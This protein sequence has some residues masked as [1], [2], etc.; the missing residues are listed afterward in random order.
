MKSFPPGLTAYHTLEPANHGR[1]AFR[2]VSGV[3]II[4]ADYPVDLEKLAAIAEDLMLFIETHY[5]QRAMRP[6]VPACLETIRK[7]GLKIGL[8]SNVNSRGQV[9]ANLEAYGIRHYF[10]PIV[11]SSEYGRR[12]P[13][14]AI[15]HYAARL[16]NVPT[17]ACALCRRP[18]RPRYPWRPAG[19]ISLARSRSSMIID[20]GED[21][22][23][24]HP[25]AVIADMTELVDILK[26]DDGRNSVPNS[27]C[28]RQRSSIRALL[29]D[30]GDILYFRPERGRK[31]RAFLERVRSSQTKVMSRGEREALK[32]QAYHGADL[33]GRI[34]ARRFLRLY[35][36]DRSG[37][38]RARQTSHGRG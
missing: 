7:M 8:I 12:K 14:P 21:G 6:E 9:P 36:V 30:A 4:L 22:R 26:Q 17:S 3:N 27:G 31:L 19:R 38:D 33:T 29:F 34:S 37:A 25:D 10:D 5:Y 11:L 32:Q 28:S 24:R 16:A 18:H 2:D 23:R 1:T 13:D 15:F 20:H 35:G